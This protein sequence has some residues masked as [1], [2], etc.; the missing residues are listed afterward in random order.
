VTALTA[1]YVPGSRPDRFD[2]AA[3]SGA[4][5]VI[6]DLE[7]SVSEGEKDEARDAVVSWLPRA[8]LPVQ[9][10]VNAPGTEHLA[11]DLSVLPA[12]VDL[13]VP[14]VQDVDDLRALEGRRVHAVVESALGVERSFD[15]ARAPGVVGLALGEADLAAELGIEGDES[16][17]LIRSRL[18]VAARAAGLP[19]PM[20]S[21][22]ADL[23]DLP[24][25][26]E[27]CRAG[28]RLG[29][30]GRA[31]I[32]PRQVPV[33]RD[34]FALTAEERQWAADVLAAL[35]GGSV[36]RLPDGAMVDEAMARRARSIL[37]DD[38]PAAG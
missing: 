28:R 38:G 22:F 11:R 32:H 8:D 15:I 21:V 14:K 31:A 2:K 25:L 27:S 10:R 16:F 23:E 19:R 37:A 7:D 17:A 20:M 13:R 1:L 3:R 34:V 12:D 30:L 5:V 36:A 26:A 6:L 9:V 18:V 24:G 29:M 4:D 33:I 35:R